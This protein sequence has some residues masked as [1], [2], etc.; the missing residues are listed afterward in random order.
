[1]TQSPRTEAPVRPSFAGNS[2]TVRDGDHR[3]APKA[4]HS[5][6]FFTLSCRI[7]SYYVG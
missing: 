1:M 4:R 7:T 6:D 5:W 3:A 2:P